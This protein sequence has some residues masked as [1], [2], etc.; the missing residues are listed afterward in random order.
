MLISPQF[1]TAAIKGI[2]IDRWEESLQEIPSWDLKKILKGK[3]LG[4][5]FKI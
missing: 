4:I 1:G 3:S 2:K 5:S